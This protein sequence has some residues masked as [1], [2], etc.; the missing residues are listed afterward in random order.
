VT[1]IHFIRMGFSPFWKRLVA[2]TADDGAT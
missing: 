2:M 1:T